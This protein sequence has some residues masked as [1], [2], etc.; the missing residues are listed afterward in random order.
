MLRMGWGMPA[1]LMAQE[2]LRAIGPHVNGNS[3]YD[4]VVLSRQQSALAR[5]SDTPRRLE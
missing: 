2:T 3:A 5:P 4:A 1:A